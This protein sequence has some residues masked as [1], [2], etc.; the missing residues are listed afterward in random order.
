M[1][2]ETFKNMPLV[3]MMAACREAVKELHTSA[4]WLNFLMFLTYFGAFETSSEIPDALDH[5]A[6]SGSMGDGVDKEKAAPWDILYRELK[7]FR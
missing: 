5:S 4:E 3:N 2:Q 7:A 1:M 6:D